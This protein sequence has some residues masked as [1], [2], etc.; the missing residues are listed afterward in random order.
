VGKATSATE[1]TLSS[2]T[3]AHGDEQAELLTATVTPQYPGTTP[4]GAITIKEG[5]IK[6]CTLTL[7]SGSTSC[8]LA[9]GKLP[10]GT[11]QVVATYAGNTNFLSSTSVADT[12]TVSN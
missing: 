7:S 3:I 4:T 10:T 8:T 6:L 1:L 9:A 5:G 2:N 12:L 11:F